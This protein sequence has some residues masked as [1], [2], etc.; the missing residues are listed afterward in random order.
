VTGAPV[1]ESIRRTPAAGRPIAADWRLYWPAAV[2]RRLRLW[3][4]SIAA[5]TFGVLVV[6]GITRLTQSG[7]SIVDWHPVSG[8]IPPLNDVQW[9]DAFNRYREYPE[10]QQLRSG[11]TLGDFKSIFFWEYL[12]R[13][14]ARLIGVVF[15]VPCAVF[16]WRGEL[17]PPLARRAAALFALGA[18]QGGLGWLM[19]RSGLIDRP[20]VSHYR[21]AAHLALAF[22]IF[23]Y[24]VWLAR[25]LADGPSGASVPAGARRVMRRG[26]VILGLLLA[27]QII[28]G[29]LVAGLDAGYAFNTFP[30]MAGKLVP[31]GLL[32][33]TPAALS[34][35]ENIA[36][37]QWVHRLL[38]TVLLATAVVFC[39]R[40]GAS[41]ADQRSRRL[42][43]AFASLIAVQ[44]GLGVATL[45]YSVPIGLG[46]LHQAVALALAGVWVV[47]AHH[48]CHLVERPTPS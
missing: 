33:S 23:G 27:V 30:L 45:I 11:M 29:A 6:G 15:L 42:S 17:I 43:A 38:G 34:F 46:G 9:L 14:L 32:A 21:L 37:V 48:A 36:A 18:M 25:D 10:F 28:W 40:V 7:L 2:R 26:L 1:T 35:V 22:A 31:L 3:F 12:H 8:A 19:V 5:M 4:W 47:W 16:W 39:L 44:Y 24:A 41:E 20:S 13:A